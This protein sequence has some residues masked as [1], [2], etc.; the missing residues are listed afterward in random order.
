MGQGGYSWETVYN[1]PLW[2]RRFTYDRLLEH[3][4]PKNEDGPAA[5]VDD[6]IKLGIQRA[7]FA[8]EQKAKN[9]SAYNVKVSNK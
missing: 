1:M 4:K 9:N 8:E 7:K 3:Y 2:L 5:T 6:E